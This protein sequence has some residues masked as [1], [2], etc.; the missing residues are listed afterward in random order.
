VVDFLG[1]IGFPYEVHELGKTQLHIIIAD[2]SSTFPAR[3]YL[4]ARESLP[5][6][7]DL[8]DIAH[9][10]RL[11]KHISNILLVTEHRAPDNLKKYAESRA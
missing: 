10:A 2:P 8:D 4:T 11:E 1:T 7:A 3:F 9:R 6:E 5:Q